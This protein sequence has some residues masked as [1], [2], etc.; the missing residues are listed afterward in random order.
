MEICI[1]QWSKGRVSDGIK[2]DRFPTEYTSLMKHYRIYNRLEGWCP[3][4]PH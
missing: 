3:V 1:S 2:N 4:A